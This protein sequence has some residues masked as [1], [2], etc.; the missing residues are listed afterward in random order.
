MLVAKTDVPPFASEVRMI[1][2]RQLEARAG[3]GKRM[4]SDGF[5]G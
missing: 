3:D 4:E 2:V 1:G 5:I